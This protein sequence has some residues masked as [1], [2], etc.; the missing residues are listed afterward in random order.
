MKHDIKILHKVKP[1]FGCERDIYSITVTCKDNS[2]CGVC[3]C[4]YMLLPGIQPNLTVVCSAN[5]TNGLQ[6]VISN[7]LHER[8]FTQNLILI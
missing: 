8:L 6:T 3:T 1:R 4:V 2:S 7:E 5:H